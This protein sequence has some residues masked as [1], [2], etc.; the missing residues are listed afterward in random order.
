[1]PRPV[2]IHPGLFDSGPRHWQSHWEARFP[3]VTRVRQDDWETPR[4]TDWIARLDEHVRRAGDDVV[5]VGHSLACSLIVRWAEQHRRP[6]RGALLVAPSDTE[7]PSYPSGTTGFTPMPTYRLPFPS[8]A[9]ASDDDEYVTAPRARQ[10][11][12]AWGSELAL[13]PGLGHINSDSDLGMWPE[14]LALLARLSDDRYD[15]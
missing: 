1:M 4:A 7:A 15:D 12:E 9:V 11:A 6:V 14:G 13:M 3:H 5:L 10:F 2:L 8:I